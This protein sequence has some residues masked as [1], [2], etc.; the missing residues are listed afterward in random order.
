M[1]GRILGQEAVLLIQVRVALVRQEG[2]GWT[3]GNAEEVHQ[4]GEGSGNPAWSSW[5][6]VLEET[7]FLGE[8]TM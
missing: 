2:R 3:D 8:A 5:W 7:R 1:E 4:E 6:E